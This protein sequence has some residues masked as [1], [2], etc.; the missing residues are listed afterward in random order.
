[1]SDPD[2]GGRAY[3]QCGSGN[4]NWQPGLLWRT[5]G[6]DHMTWR[7]ICSLNYL[8]SE[9]W[10]RTPMILGLKKILK[11]VVFKMFSLLLVFMCMS[12]AISNL[13]KSLPVPSG[14]TQL[15]KDKPS[16]PLNF[17]KIVKFIIFSAYLFLTKVYHQTL[18][19]TF[20]IVKFSI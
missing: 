19:Q 6:R 15:K 8:K 14:E 11:Y 1:M 3:F 18:P 12:M 4:R 16:G 7:K 9:V 10:C 2:D 20:L 5:I 13:S 17:D